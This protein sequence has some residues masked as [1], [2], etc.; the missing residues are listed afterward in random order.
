MQITLFGLKSRTKAN[1]EKP[2][3]NKSQ[4][5]Q[6]KANTVFRGLLGQN[7]CPDPSRWKGSSQMRI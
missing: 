1:M 5:N 3:E 6:K 7:V 4:L 2:Q